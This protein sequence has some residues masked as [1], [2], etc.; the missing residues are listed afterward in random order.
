MRTKVV[1]H[2]ED[3]EGNAIGDL[4]QVMVDG[5]R[6]PAK[7]VLDHVLGEGEHIKPSPTFLDER[8]E[9]APSEQSAKS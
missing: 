1:F 2:I 3:S 6:K 8:V 7:I 4:L 5:P 9:G